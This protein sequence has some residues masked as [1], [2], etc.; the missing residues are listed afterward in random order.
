MSTESRTIVALA[1][2][3]S[4]ILGRLDLEHLPPL[5]SLRVDVPTRA[6][7]YQVSSY[8]L[9]LPGIM[10]L[11]L[12]WLD[13]LPGLP[14]VHAREFQRGTWCVAVVAQ[15]A[16]DATL[17]VW[18]T[19]TLIPGDVQDRM[20]AAGSRADAADVLLEHTGVASEAAG[21]AS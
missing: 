11:L 14:R 18:T 1:L 12:A 4:A 7:S 8:A 3:A 5:C 20:R 10:L 21:G 2:D 9:T 17:E 16:D 6:V 19:T 13:A 15:L